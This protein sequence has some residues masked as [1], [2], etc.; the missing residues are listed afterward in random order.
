M[1][2]YRFYKNSQGETK[3]VNTGWNWVGFFFPLIWLL[4]KQL[5]AILFIVIISVIII[6]YIV[7]PLGAVIELAFS[8]YVGMKGNSLLEVKLIDKGFRCVDSNSAA[9]QNAL[10]MGENSNY[11]PGEYACEVC[12]NK[13]APEDKYCSSC[14]LILSDMGSPTEKTSLLTSRVQQLRIAKDVLCKY[15]SSHILPYDDYCNQCGEKLVPTEMIATSGP[16]PHCSTC[17]SLVSADFTFCSQCGA[18]LGKDGVVNLEEYKDDVFDEPVV[19]DEFECSSC[20]AIVSSGYKYCI[21]C[22][23]LFE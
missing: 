6:G 8:I 5:Y 18:E 3:T 11:A 9:E 4:V 14:G 22:G 23:A 19:V 16:L 2:S 1:K 17:K 10:L 7:P 13:V 20:D 21:K 12:K 15:C